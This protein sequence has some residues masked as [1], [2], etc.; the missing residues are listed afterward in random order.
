MTMSK[1]FLI[2]LIAALM[3]ITWAIP[4][5]DIMAE[6]VFVSGDVF[7]VWSADSVIVSDSI[8]VP[9]DSSLT[10]MPGVTILVTSYY[11][12]E[13]LDNAELNAVGTET[14]SIKFLPFTEGD[15]TLGIDFINASDQSI[16]EYWYISDALSSGI[17]LDNSSITIRSC[18]IEECEAP[19]G[20]EG[21]GAVEILNGSDA[22]IEKNTFR[23][24]VS[25]SQGG[26]VFIRLSSPIIRENAII[27]NFASAGNASGGG[28]QIEDGS[29]TQLLDNFISDNSATALG[30]FSVRHGKG[31]GIYISGGFNIV[32]SG[33]TISDNR[34]NFEPQTTAEGGGLYIV[35]S[36][37][38]ISNNLIVR[39]DAESNNGGGIYLD[40]SDPMILNNTFSNNHSGERGGA[41]YGEVSHPVIVNSILYYNEDSAGTEISL[42][43]FSTA[44]VSYSDIEGSW[45]GIGNLDTD[46]MYRD[47]I[48]GD[49]HLI[50]QMCG[51][52]FD[53][54]L[55][56]AGSPEWADSL[57]NCSWGLN[58]QASDIGAYGGGE[59]IP[60]ST[61]EEI[62]PPSGFYLADNYPNPFNAYTTI[63]FRLP[64]ASNVTLEIY[65]LLGRKI[66]TLIDNRQQSAGV[67]NIKWEA[68]DAAT[69][70][71]FYRLQA[72]NYRITKK[73]ALLK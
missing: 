27:N 56:D 21:G 7:G 60:T 64:E 6:V 26:G 9:A 42:D 12:F 5:S 57:V 59:M 14:D 52:Q 61:D 23:D 72:N 36:D 70:V 13:V 34:V 25:I 11:K 10:I 73:M 20:V 67:H 41:I 71:Y 33:N 24:N 50:A 46:P 43:N 66:E 4:G 39:N 31:G 32:I 16:M 69:G 29:D 65:S 17:H 1:R 54:P 15:R 68:S 18:L 48:A 3:A 2:T 22:L 49:Y 55:I 45:P 19:T 28:I 40:G 35:N 30:S 47:I 44:T 8:Q 53:S 62:E 37:P 51:H 38:F 58:T 63:S